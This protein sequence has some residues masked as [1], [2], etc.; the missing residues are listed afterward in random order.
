[1][2]F[3]NKENI[4]YGEFKLLSN[5]TSVSKELVSLASIFIFNIFAMFKKILTL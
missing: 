4:Q 2:K 1:M 3:D 5:G